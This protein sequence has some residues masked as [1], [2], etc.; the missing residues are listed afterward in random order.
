MRR[1]RGR[2]SYSSK[3]FGPTFVSDTNFPSPL[4]HNPVDWSANMYDDVSKF[5]LEIYVSRTTTSNSS[6]HSTWPTEYPIPHWKKSFKTL[7]VGHY[8][9]QLLSKYIHSRIQILYRSPRTANMLTIKTS[10]EFREVASRVVLRAEDLIPEREPKGHWRLPS[11][12]SPQERN[13][14]SQNLVNLFKRYYV[15]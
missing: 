9:S 3:I 14:Q 5:C 2:S 10:D 15:G 8:I 11:L 7:L 12:P 6:Q 4:S 13:E 1:S